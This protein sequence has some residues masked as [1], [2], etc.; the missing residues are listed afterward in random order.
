MMFT[1]LSAILKKENDEDLLQYIP[2]SSIQCT[3]EPAPPGC[4]S[5]LVDAISL[6]SAPPLDFISHRDNREVFD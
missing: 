6:E 4:L 5:V 1:R 3:I 2:L